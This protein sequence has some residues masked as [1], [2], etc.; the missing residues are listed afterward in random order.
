MHLKL[1]ELLINDKISLHFCIDVSM[2]CRNWLNGTVVSWLTVTSTRSERTNHL[3][4]G[5][6]TALI[7]DLIVD[8]LFEVILCQYT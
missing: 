4:A 8:G 3:V 6:S 7:K 5:P 1:L 2:I